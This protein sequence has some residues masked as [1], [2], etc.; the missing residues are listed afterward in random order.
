ML[1]N[2]RHTFRNYL[3]FAHLAAESLLRVALV[4]VPPSGSRAPTSPTPAPI[5]QAVLDP[6]ALHRRLPDR[7]GNPASAIERGDCDA[8]TICAAAGREQRPAWRSSRQATTA[9][10]KPCT[11]CNKCLHNVLE[12]PIGCYEE[13]RFAS[14]EE[15][16]GEI[17]SVFEPFPTGAP[18]ACRR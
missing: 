13:R 4:Q 18:T 15:M 14:R 9:P 17:M 2:G 1:S 7:L 8:V 16:I 10:P 3:V 6:G 5:K 11:Y 12:H